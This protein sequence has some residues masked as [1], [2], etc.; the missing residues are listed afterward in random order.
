MTDDN[1]KISKPV[2][3]HFA[4]AAFPVIS[5]I[6]L[7]PSKYLGDM[8]DFD[9]SDEQKLA[10]LEALWSV[11][12]SFVELGFSLKDCGQLTDIF[13]EA[14]EGCAPGVTIDVT[15]QPVDTATKA[16]TGKASP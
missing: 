1:N 16:P 8:D 10:L 12:R 6:Q 3:L 4:E 7:D 2:S 15:A 9:V 11:M 5:E 13:N 14:A